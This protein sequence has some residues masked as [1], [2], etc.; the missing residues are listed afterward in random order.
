MSAI[1][2]ATRAGIDLSLIEENLR[3]TP[4]QRAIRHQAALNMA[5]QLKAAFDASGRDDRNQ[6][7]SADALRR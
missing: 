4:E 5:L 2:E 3:L 7:T 6:S 1:D